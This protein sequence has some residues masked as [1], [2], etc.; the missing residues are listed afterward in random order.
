MKN[1]ELKAKFNS[2][3]FRIN[4]LLA[5][6]I[7]IKDLCVMCEERVVLAAGFKYYFRTRAKT[8]PV[9]Y[10]LA[11]SLLKGAGYGTIYLSTRIERP[12]KDHCGRLFNLANRLT[13]IT[14]TGERE[15]EKLF[16]EDYVYASIEAEHELIFTLQCNFGKSMLIS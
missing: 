9:P 3:A 7:P 13:A 12:S 10:R 2:I 6:H 5:G 16:I 15:K 4:S 1:D 8:Q 11:I 14:Y